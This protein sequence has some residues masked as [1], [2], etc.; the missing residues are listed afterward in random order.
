MYRSWLAALVYLA[1]CAGPCGTSAS[2]SPPPGEPPVRT[3]SMAEYNSNVQNWS[4]ALGTDGLIYIGGGMGLL[5]YDGVRW[6]RHDTP[7][8]ARVRVLHIEE[9]DDASARFWIGSTNEFGYFQRKPDGAMRYH[10]VSDQLPEG[11]R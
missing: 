4:A 1:L 5:E 6:T 2:E 7:N 11:Q 8:N 9:Q 10:S 3:F